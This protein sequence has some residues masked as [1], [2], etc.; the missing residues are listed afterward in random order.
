MLRLCIKCLKQRWSSGTMPSRPASM[1]K[2]ALFSR[3]GIPGCL[4]LST[5]G[6]CREVAGLYVGRFQLGLIW[7][8]RIFGA[9]IRSPT[10]ALLG[11]PR[12]RH[13]SHVG[14]AVHL[15]RLRV[16]RGTGQ[17]A[18]ICPCTSAQSQEREGLAIEA[19][20]CMWLRRLTSQSSGRLPARCACI[21]PPLISS[22]RLHRRHASRL[23]LP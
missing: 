18:P 20:S 3:S 16:S 13:S 12:Q 21:R 15:T 14:V 22:V 4:Q 19:W 2:T 7:R 1:S 11:Q 5:T 9:K 6:A 8:S 17:R 10:S 23:V